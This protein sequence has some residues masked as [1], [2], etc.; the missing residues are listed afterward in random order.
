MNL[1]HCENIIWEI[2][3]KVNVK[4]E[5]RKMAKGTGSGKGRSRVRLFDGIKREN[6]LV[7]VYK[8]TTYSVDEYVRS[9]ERVKRYCG[10]VKFNS[11]VLDIVKSVIEENSGRKAVTGYDVFLRRCQDKNIVVCVDLNNEFMDI[12]VKKCEDICKVLI[13]LVFNRLRR[14]FSGYSENE[15]DEVSDKLEQVKV[16]ISELIRSDVK[17]IARKKLVKDS[18]INHA[19]LVYANIMEDEDKEKEEK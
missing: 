10:E 16:M 4:G 9:G 18:I 8:E 1:V 15:Y 12:G 7:K 19:E 6:V 14:K 3:Q 5:T 17:G 11:S 2:K 13:D